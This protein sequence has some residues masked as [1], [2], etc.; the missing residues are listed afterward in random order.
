MARKTIFILRHGEI[1]TG[2]W[3]LWR[4]RN[5]ASIDRDD[6][7]LS[8]KGLS[9]SEELGRLFYENKII[10]EAIVVSP[11]T[12][13]IQTAT[14]IQKSLDYTTD[15]ILNPLLGEYEFMWK[16][17]CASYPFGIVPIYLYKTDNKIDKIECKYPEKYEDM[18]SRCNFIIEKLI[19]KYDNL[20][21]VSHSSI[22]KYLAKYLSQNDD[23]EVEINFSD[24]IK[25]TIEDGKTTVEVINW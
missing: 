6:P 24:Y 4:L 15:I 5:F 10:P 8:A 7:P 23:L 17:T 25:V 9:K 19:N 13:C 11:F 18:N 16:H 21:I 22:V 3:A 12:R 14:Q 1:E 20:I 2:S